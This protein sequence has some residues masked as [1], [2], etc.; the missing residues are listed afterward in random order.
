MKEAKADADEAGVAEA[1]AAEVEAA[2]EGSGVTAVMQK[3]KEAKR[4]RLR[5]LL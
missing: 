1:A 5:N 4:A 3:P 2:V